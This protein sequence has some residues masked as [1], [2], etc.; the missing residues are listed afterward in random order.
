[1]ILIWVTGASFGLTPFQSNFIDY[2][3]CD[4]HVKDV[5]KVKRIVRKPLVGIMRGI[6]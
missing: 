4:I 6:G 5:T 2:V 1:M 3:K